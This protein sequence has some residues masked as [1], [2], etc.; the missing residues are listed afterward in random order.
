V[1]RQTAMSFE[2]L[3][4]T[5]TAVDQ[6]LGLEIGVDRHFWDSDLT[7]M[8]VRALPD[9]PSWP[10]IVERDKGERVYQSKTGPRTHIF[11]VAGHIQRRVVEPIADTLTRIQPQARLGFD[12]EAWME[13]IR[14]GVF[15]HMARGGEFLKIIP[16]LTVS[17]DR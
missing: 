14:Q 16:D 7:T 12:R 10:M 11:D 4:L 15:V 5:N 17:I 2:Y 3:S 6:E 1:E 8:L 13:A 9:G